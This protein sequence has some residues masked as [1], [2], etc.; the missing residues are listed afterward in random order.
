MVHAW[1]FAQLLR[2]ICYEVE[3]AGVQVVEEAPGTPASGAAA[4]DIRNVATAP[5]RRPSAANH[6]VTGHTRI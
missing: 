2:F 3:L 6:V 5:S 4:A 1:P